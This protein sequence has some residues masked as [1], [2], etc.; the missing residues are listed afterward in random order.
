MAR[1]RD[2]RKDIRNFSIALAVLL[3]GFAALAF[4]RERPFWPPLLIT[5][6]HVLG[7]GLFI[8]RL[9]KPVFKGFMWFAEKMNWVVTRVMLTVIWLTMFVPVGLV[10]RLLRIDFF[11]RKIEPERAGY[12]NERPD[13]PYDRHRAERLG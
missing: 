3:G 11:D 12:W 5:A 9:M 13:K 8:P 7:F 6:L 4:Y 10:L 2:E 1:K